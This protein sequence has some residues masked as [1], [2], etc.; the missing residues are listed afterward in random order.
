M[1]PYQVGFEG[2]VDIHR[3]IATAF[4]A[5]IAQPTDLALMRGAGSFLLAHHSLESEV[6]FPILRREG[7]LRSADVS[8]LD[9]FDRAHHELHSLCVRLLDAGPGSAGSLARAIKEVLLDHVAEEEV[10]LAPDRMRC[11]IGAHVFDEVQRESD[12]LREKLQASL[13]K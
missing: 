3:R 5:A 1:D 2:L 10:G 4:D 7:R 8:F 13:R 9:P 12:R 11:L 6:L